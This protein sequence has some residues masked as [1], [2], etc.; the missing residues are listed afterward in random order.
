[1]IFAFPGL[2]FR[3]GDILHVINASDKEWWQARRVVC[4]TSICSLAAYLRCLLLQEQGRDSEEFGVVPA[5]ER[6][7]RKERARLKQV[8]FSQHQPSVIEK[9]SRN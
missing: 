7:E 9:V 4:P 6:V 5:R 8:K 2:S 1:M 3:Y